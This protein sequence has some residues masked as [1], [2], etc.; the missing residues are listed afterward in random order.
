[1]AG[2]N[3]QIIAIYHVIHKDNHLICKTMEEQKLRFEVYNN[4]T[5]FF[6]IKFKMH[7]NPISWT[8][9]NK[10]TF[11]KRVSWKKYTYM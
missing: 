10:V 9:T 8:W 2:T 1:M 6:I 11:L 4:A 5:T 3:Y 7:N